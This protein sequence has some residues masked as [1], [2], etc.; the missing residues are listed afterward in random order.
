MENSKKEVHLKH[1]DSTFIRV[2]S[3]VLID[4]WYLQISK[5]TL[6]SGW[7]FWRDSSTSTKICTFSWFAIDLL[8]I[9]IVYST[10]LSQ[11][12]SQCW[13]KKYLP[14]VAKGPLNCLRHPMYNSTK[15]IGITWLQHGS[16]KEN[17]LSFCCLF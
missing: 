12:I 15:T 10:D 7:L 4:T 5:L 17:N 14:I 6:K 11:V 9:Y 13:G 8:A 1:D 2:S 16:E 3:S